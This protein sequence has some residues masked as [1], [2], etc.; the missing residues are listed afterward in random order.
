[1]HGN[2]DNTFT[3]L[4]R[5]KIPVGSLDWFAGYKFK[6]VM[7]VIVT[8]KN[9][10]PMVEVTQPIQK[11]RD[12]FFGGAGTHLLGEREIYSSASDRLGSNFEHSAALP[13]Y[14]RNDAHF[15]RRL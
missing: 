4:C 1:M 14:S 11:N 9:T 5:V 6:K 13:L 10:K 3:L 12:G 7:D 8:L 15:V 2:I